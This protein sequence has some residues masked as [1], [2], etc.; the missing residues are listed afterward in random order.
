MVNSFL[1]RLGFWLVPGTCILCS[2]DSHRRR[3]LCLPCER[4]LPW[5][6]AS[7][8]RCAYPMGNSAELCGRCLQSPPS[9]NHTTAL[10]HY[11]GPVQHLISQFKY[12]H[13]TSYGRVM[14]ELLTEALRQR[15]APPPELIAA[16][17]MHWRRRWQRGGNH[18]DKLAEILAKAL[19]VPVLTGL[20]RVTHGPTQQGLSARERQ[21][22]LKGAFTLKPGVNI[23]GKSI[24]LV[25]DV[26]TTGATAEAISNTLRRAGAREVR[27]WCLARTPLSD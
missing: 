21:R 13:R 9:F 3:D 26:L 4:E 23:E 17:P 22:N 25:D 11:Q 15:S 18:C 5:L 12:Q 27:V 10:W 6:G 7:C 19:D 16:V 8:E 1:N 20:R 24:A 2:A 14:S